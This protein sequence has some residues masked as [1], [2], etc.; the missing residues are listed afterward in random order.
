MTKFK[1]AIMG[2]GGIANKF[3][4]AVNKIDDCEVVAASSKSMERALEFTH[5]NGIQSAYDNYERM[6]IQ[7]KPDCVYI[8]VTANAHYELTML[9]LDYKVPILCEKAMFLNSLQAETV[10]SRAAKLNVFVMEA[11]WSRFLPAVNKAKQWIEEGRVG[12]PSWLEIAVG[13]PAPAD[14][15]N[16]YFNPDLGGGAS[17]DV[18]V[19]AYEIATYII[20]QPIE[21]L[22]VSATFAA[23]GVDVTN[24]ISIRFTDVLASLKSSLNSL[25]DEKLVIYG[26]KGKLV[27]P[28]PH[29]AEEAFI[30]NSKQEVVEH[31]KD[32]E[33]ENGFVYQ[34]KEAMKCIRNGSI[35]S[36]I[37]PHELTIQCARIFD[38][39]YDC[40]P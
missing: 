15:S 3:C 37:V 38:R 20:T 4:D 39:I 19:Y 10:F 28:Y 33:T 6:L 35:E 5:R 30:F 17:F 25:M 16:R 18:T 29:F 11:M 23:T 36:S 34:I 8:A 1:F 2:A 27:V 12:K 21:E 7:E 40:R 14:N 31:Y 24:H 32:E 13:F 22:Q 26:D 9:C